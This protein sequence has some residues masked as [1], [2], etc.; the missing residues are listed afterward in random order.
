MGGGGWTIQPNDI[1]PKKKGRNKENF[2][3]Y[4]QAFQ[5]SIGVKN[6]PA[7]QETRR[8]AFDPLY[9]PQTIEVF[10][11]GNGIPLQYSCLENPMDGGAW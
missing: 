7:M 1:Y 4:L 3:I 11:E 10:G 9:L 6:P 8:H 2:Y 5:V